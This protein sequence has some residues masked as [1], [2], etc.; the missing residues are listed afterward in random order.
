MR[1]THSLLHATALL[2]LLSIAIIAK[3]QTPTVV[4]SDNFNR[5]PFTTGSSGGI[6]ATLYKFT[7]GAGSTINTVLVSGV[8]YKVNINSGTNANKSLFYA[9]LAPYSSPFSR[10]L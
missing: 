9:P 5:T 4:F 6:P 8:N 1:Y 7:L 2:C 10:K 3:G